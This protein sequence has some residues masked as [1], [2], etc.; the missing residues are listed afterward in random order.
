MKVIFLLKIANKTGF[1][2]HRVDEKIKGIFEKNRKNYSKTQWTGASDYCLLPPDFR[3]NKCLQKTR[4]IFD[5]GNVKRNR[6][7]KCL[8]Q[9]PKKAQLKVRIT[10]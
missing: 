8:G 3:P 7:R 9:Q 1:F 4:A 10:N 6:Q 5:F 2:E